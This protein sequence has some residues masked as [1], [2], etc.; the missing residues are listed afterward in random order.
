M[1]YQEK[2]AKKQENICEFDAIVIIRT[3]YKPFQFMEN[4]HSAFS[5]VVEPY[6]SFACVRVVLMRIKKKERVGSFEVTL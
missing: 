2:I 3:H 4:Y 1:F 6:G 5:V